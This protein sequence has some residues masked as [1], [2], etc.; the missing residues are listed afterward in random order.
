M[1][2]IVMKTK[3]LVTAIAVFASIAILGASAPIFAAEK[4]QCDRECLVKFMK[5]YL[6]ALVKHDP[7]ALPWAFRC[8]ITTVHSKNMT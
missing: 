8:F 3:Y 2:V 4:Y 6:S 5:D 1:G 7:K